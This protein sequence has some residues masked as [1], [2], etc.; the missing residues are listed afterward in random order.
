MMFLEVRKHV[1]LTVLVVAAASGCGSSGSGGDG[2][3]GN[4]AGSGGQSGS[5]GH[6]GTGGEAAGGAGGG[7]PSGGASGTDAGLATTCTGN[8][9]VTGG[10]CSTIEATGPCVTTTTSAAPV[11]TPTGAVNGVTAGSYDLMASTLYTADGGTNHEPARRE[12]LSIDGVTKTSFVLNWTQVSGTASMRWS[13]E[14]TVDIGQI[15]Y[16]VTCPE[17]ASEQDFD[18]SF[19]AASGTLSFIDPNAPGG[20]LVSTYVL[21]PPTTD[22]SVD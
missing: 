16:V 13:G 12:T 20:T 19:D 6:G 18:F 17:F 10:G 3:A 8:G 2:G 21:Q 14:V 1:W 22:A 4:N 7:T 5:A 9:Q 11:P 15:S